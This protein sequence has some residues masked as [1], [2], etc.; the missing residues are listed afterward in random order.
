VVGCEFEEEVGVG[1]GETC[2]GEYGESRSWL[3]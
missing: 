1:I 2:A 3:G